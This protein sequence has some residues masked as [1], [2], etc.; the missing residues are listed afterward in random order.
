MPAPSQG[1]ACAGQSQPPNHLSMFL[2]VTEPQA[3][4]PAWSYF[5]SHRLSVVNKDE[6]KNVTKESQNRWA[7][8]GTWSAAPH[9]VYIEQVLRQQQRHSAASLLRSAG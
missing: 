3:S 8:S 9:R 4:T 2:E 7:E 5:V 6:S 1:A